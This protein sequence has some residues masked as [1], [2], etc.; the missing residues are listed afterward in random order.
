MKFVIFATLRRF[1]DATAMI[2]AI[3]VKQVVAMKL[4]YLVMGLFLGWSS[5]EIRHASIQPSLLLGHDRFAGQ[6]AQAANPNQVDQLRRTNQC[7]NCDLSGANLA[8]ANLYG[9]NLVNANLRG[10]NLKGA[11][12]GAANLSD[13]NLS[14]ADLSN[15]YLF[16]AI[17]DGTNLSNANLQLAYLREVK[18]NN[19]NL[20]G[21][22]LKGINLSHTNLGSVSLKDA[23]LRDANLNYTS[24]I[25]FRVPGV[26]PNDNSLR[27]LAPLFLFQTGCLTASNSDNFLNSLRDSGIEILRTDLTGTNL[28]RAN[29]SH[30][31]LAN[32]VLDG[33]NL[34]NANLTGATL[35]C[36]SLKNAVL[37]G[38]DLKNTVL[39][40]TILEG[41][42]T[43]DVKNANL[44]GVVPAVTNQQLRG[45][46]AQ[47][48][49]YVGAMNRAQQAYFLEKNQFAPNI[50]ALGIGIREETEEYQYRIFHYPR[51]DRAV[52]LA[53][54]PKRG[55]FKSYIGLVHVSGTSAA[56]NM[57]TWSALCESQE[58]IPLLPKLPALPSPSLN[59]P[60]ACPE[61]FISVR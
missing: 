26:N 20:Q 23:D 25:D 17:L 30:A 55:G 31:M 53:G 60:M 18:L 59:Q 13:A 51:R 32:L 41:A 48:R 2:E 21:A 9:A 46:Q 39:E 35:R 47:A 38:A 52:M 50:Q 40:A 10:A 24:F 28:S 42:S 11:N 12:L 44:G 37:D 5:G 8:E 4:R 43:Q 33:A 34:R 19:V 15:A 3:S 27:Q 56:K 45:H 54:I 57:T 22:N 6:S 7:P 36:S 49:S 61:G 14:E 16:T 1:I 29:L 58:A